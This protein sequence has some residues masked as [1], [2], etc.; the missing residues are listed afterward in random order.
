M[1]WVIYQFRLCWVIYQVMLGWVIYQVRLGY[2]VVIEVISGW[3]IYVDG[4][5]GVFGPF[6]SNVCFFL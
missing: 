5:M 2:Q 3:V 6:V 4:I 1:G